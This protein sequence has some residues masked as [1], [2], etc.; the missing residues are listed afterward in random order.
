MIRKLLIVFASGLLLAIVSISLAGIIGGPDLSKAVRSGEGFSIVVDGDKS[1]AP[2]VTKSLEFDTGKPF[3]LD[4]PIE[5]RFT[6]GDKPELTLSGPSDVVEALE[7][8]D[9]Q[10]KLIKDV[11]RLSTN[12]LRMTLVAPVMPA[13]ELSSVGDV[14]L[15]GLDQQSLIINASG[16][17]SVDAEGKVQTVTVDSSGASNIDLGQLQA[18]DAK[19]DLSGVGNAEINAGGTVEINI[20]GAGNVSLL[21]KPA[22]LKSQTSGLGNIDHDY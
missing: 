9:G 4:V 2:K 10:L 21:R 15:E 3:V 13:L 22:V 6:K 7:W 5:F 1:N 18:Q 19:V 11:K 16:A 14:K 8:K 17:A 20:S 12:G